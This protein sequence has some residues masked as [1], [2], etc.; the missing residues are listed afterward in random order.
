MVKK[1]LW[2]ARM[3]S[4]ASTWFTFKNTCINTLYMYKITRG[5]VVGIFDLRAVSRGLEFQRSKW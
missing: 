2:N 3:D 1:L 4:T 5:L